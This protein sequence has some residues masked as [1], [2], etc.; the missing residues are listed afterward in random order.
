MFFPIVHILLRHF[1]A[2]ETVVNVLGIQHVISV[3]KVLIFC[4]SVT[5]CYSHSRGGE[6]ADD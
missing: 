3:L 2:Q 4:S 5:F 1:R 6:K